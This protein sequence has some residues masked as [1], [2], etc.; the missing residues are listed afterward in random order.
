MSSF[1]S[2]NIQ[3]YILPSIFK[4]THLHQAARDAAAPVLAQ[5]KYSNIQIFKCTHLHQAARDAA[6]PY[7][8]SNNQ[9]LRITAP[10][11]VCWCCGVP[12]GLAQAAR[13]PGMDP[14]Y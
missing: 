1:P 12:C 9:I 10:N 7:K 11:Y 6:A 2:T 3:M 4:C 13:K 5:Y 8:Y 14:L